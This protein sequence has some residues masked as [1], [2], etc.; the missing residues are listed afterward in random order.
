MDLFP[1]QSPPVTR[2]DIIPLWDTVD[3]SQ[4]TIEELVSVYMHLTHG[5]NYDDPAPWLG[6]SFLSRKTGR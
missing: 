5:A 4:G 6:S 3:V 2:P 1:I